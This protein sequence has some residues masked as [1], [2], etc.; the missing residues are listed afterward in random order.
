MGARLFGR[1]RIASALL[2]NETIQRLSRFNDA[3]REAMSCCK[4]RQEQKVIQAF[5][6]VLKSVKDN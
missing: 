6:V 2:I 1:F 4:E 3:A 5:G